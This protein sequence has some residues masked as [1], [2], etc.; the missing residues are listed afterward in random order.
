MFL[1]MAVIS[2]GYSHIKLIFAIILF[3]I[4]VYLDWKY[5]EKDEPLNKINLED[6]KFSKR[7]N[8]Y[9]SDE[10]EARYLVTPLFME[11]LD[12]LKT[13]FNSKT[14][15]CSFFDDNLMIAISTKKDVFEIGDLSIPCDNPKFI[16][17]FWRELSSIYK[18]VEYFKLNE[19]THLQN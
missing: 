2:L 10:V 17:Q 9:S 4:F 12:N 19:K 16:L 6:P 5:G 15:K 3:I 14:I 11:L 7:F 18:M 13:A 8:V 1:I